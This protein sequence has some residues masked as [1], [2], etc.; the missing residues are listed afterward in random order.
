VSTS[1][2][3][4]AEFRALRQRLELLSSWGPGDRR[5]ALNTISPERV[6]AAAGEVQVGRTVQCR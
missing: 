6:L 4:S 5:G 1:E 3:G 2:L